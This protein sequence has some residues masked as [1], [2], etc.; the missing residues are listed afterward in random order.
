L[1]LGHSTLLNTL[2]IITGIL[3]IA[4]AAKGTMA[5]FGMTFKIMRIIAT[6]PHPSH[7]IVAINLIRF[8]YFFG[9]TG[10]MISKNIFS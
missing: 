2:K 8:T 7:D 10:G 1:H 6:D 4:I 3:P 9:V 5:I